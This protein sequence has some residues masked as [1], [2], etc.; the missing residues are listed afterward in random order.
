MSLTI[1]QPRL[2]IHHLTFVNKIL[3]SPG[4]LATR[5]ITLPTF[6]FTC[7][8][9]YN[10]IMALHRLLTL[11]SVLYFA[12][13]TYARPHFQPRTIEPVKFTIDLC[14][15]DWAPTGAAPRQGILTNGT[16]PGP[17]LH[18]KQGDDVE[19]LVYN[20]LNYPTAI[21]FHGIVQTNTPWSD[22][23]PGVTQHAI[24]PGSSFL[25]KWTADQ[26]GVYFYHAHYQSQIMDGMY[27]AIVIEPKDESDRPWSLI[28]SDPADYAHMTAADTA[29][30]PVFLSDY[31]K[32]T[33][34]EFH[35]I[36][37]AGNIDFACT[38]AILING[39][40]ST[41]CL[42]R[43]EITS[44]TSP[45][46]APLLKA[47][48]PP[49][50]TDKGC[51]PPNIPAI[52]GNFTF[53][54]DAIP[55][56]AYFD[57]TPSEGEKPTITVDPSVNG[58]WKAMTFINT[59]GFEALK[60]TI[61]SH[62]FW[63]YAV[64]GHYVVPQLVDQ[65]TANNGDRY[66]VMIKLDQKPAEYTI[67]VANNGL[68]QVI[69]G[70]G[71]FAY[72]GATWPA[73]E[74][75]NALAGMNY[76]GVN[77]TQLV[78]FIDAKASPYPPVPVSPTADATFFFNVKKLNNPHTWTLSGNEGFNVTRDDGFPLILQ[79]PD[80]IPEEE[81]II[82]TSMGQWVD[83]IIKVEGPIAVPHPMHKHS[84]KAFVL[85]QGTGAWNWSSVAEAAAVLPAGTFN[86]DNPPYRDGYTTTP[87]EQN[88][89]WMALRY[90]VVNPGPF[91]LHC[92]MQTHFSGGMAIAMLDG[93]DQW[94]SVPQEYVEGA[95]HGPVALKKKSKV[96]TLS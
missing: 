43:E 70:F 41:T 40:G 67:R 13:S 33:S 3:V 86:F 66:S 56:D 57:C 25:Y 8:A 58:G 51:L 22:G 75:P 46:L 47:V 85:G 73:S 92:H 77:L 24:Q 96:H 63:V 9:S 37:E 39:V 48:N 28:S 16:I 90:E 10:S 1:F 64:D 44:F 94:P 52:Q 54:I 69:S 21:H 91:L 38:D 36:E 59:G 89:A 26:A 60:F 76:A 61:D 34:S 88:S 18:I 79:Q 49:Q 71:T 30:E 15:G 87:A 74:D 27:G 82:R 65:I 31:S 45:I 78:R 29:L 62:K 35:A 95:G 93:V 7:L 81:V 68:N 4:Y 50:L 20:N 14:H 23:V 72:A 12:I 83:L 32:Y 6:F 84:N 53:N 2:P 80:E 17:A 11:L 5:L 42:S 55:R 19:F